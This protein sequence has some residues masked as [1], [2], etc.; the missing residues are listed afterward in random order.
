[1][2]GKLFDQ[3]WTRVSPEFED[4]PD[5]LEDTRIRLAT[6]ILEL[7]RDGQLG[8]P[9]NH[10]HGRSPHSPGRGAGK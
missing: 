6:I 8:A 2:L 5:R 3:V 9:S 4:H 7:A 1:M 10:R